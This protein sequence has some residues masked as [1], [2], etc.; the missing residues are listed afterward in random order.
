MY[1]YQVLPGNDYG[2]VD[3][4]F[5]DASGAYSFSLAPGTYV[6]DFWPGDGI[7]QEEMYDDVPG[8]DLDGATRVVVSDDGTVQATR[9]W[10]G[11]LPSPATSPTRRATAR[12]VFAYDQTD[13]LVGYGF[14]QE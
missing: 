8:F 5:T 6:I 10:F 11:P 7:H 13:E 9:S 3:A 12:L 14:V 2:F 1:V 4:A